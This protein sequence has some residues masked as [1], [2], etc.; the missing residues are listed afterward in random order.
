MNKTVL[1][2]PA[3][4]RYISDWVDFDLPNFPVIINKQLPGCGFTDFCIKNKKNVIL[5]RKIRR[6]VQCERARHER[7]FDLETDFSHKKSG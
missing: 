2:V 4:V 1:D 5:C 7:K 3:G 6:H